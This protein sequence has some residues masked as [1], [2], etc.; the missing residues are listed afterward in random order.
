MGCFKTALF[1]RK[2]SNCAWLAMGAIALVLEEGG[3]RR[4]EEKTEEA[5][6]LF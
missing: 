4:E 2:V 6:G 5:E 1:V 3:G